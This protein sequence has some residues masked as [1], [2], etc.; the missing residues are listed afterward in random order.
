[1]RN[2]R[3]PRESTTSGQS[4]KTRP[5]RAE[6]ITKGEVMLNAQA[7]AQ[8]LLKEGADTWGAKT[9][10]SRSSAPASIT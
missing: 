10:Q 8:R 1:L 7:D 3:T 4:I 6:P 9:A 5:A 2:T